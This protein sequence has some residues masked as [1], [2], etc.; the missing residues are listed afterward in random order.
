MIEN[1]AQAIAALRAFAELSTKEQQ[2]KG[3][4]IT[5]AFRKFMT[6]NPTEDEFADACGHLLLTAR[7]FYIMATHFR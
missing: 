4:E 3:S 1:K 5:K 6:F 7:M 2:S